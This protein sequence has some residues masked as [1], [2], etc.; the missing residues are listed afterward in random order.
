MTK[1]LVTEDIRDFLAGF[2]AA[3]ELDQL[4]VDASTPEMF[5][6]EYDDN[7]WRRSLHR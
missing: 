2:A 1:T 3:I 5:H 4:R 6:P 7:M